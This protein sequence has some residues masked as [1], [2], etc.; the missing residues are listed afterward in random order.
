MVGCIFRTVDDPGVMDSLKGVLGQVYV[1]EG[2][3]EGG[4]V[5]LVRVGEVDGECVPGFLLDLG[6]L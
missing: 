5:S 1:V 6:H 4:A 3:H 2:G